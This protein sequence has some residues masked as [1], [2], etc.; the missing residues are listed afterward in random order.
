MTNGCRLT[1]RELG[2]VA[3]DRLV[4]YM[5]LADSVVMR[6]AAVPSRQTQHFGRFRSEA[7]IDRAAL[8][9]SG[10]MTT[11]ASSFQI[12]TRSGLKPRR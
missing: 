7:D 11:R 3:C 6:A 12:A 4:P 10:F 8:T 9:E 2:P 5:Q 1:G